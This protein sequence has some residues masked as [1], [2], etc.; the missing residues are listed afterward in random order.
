MRKVFALFGTIAINGINTVKKDLTGLDKS[1]KDISKEMNKTGRQLKKLGKDMSKTFTVPI[2][3]MGAAATKFGGDFEKA[4][5]TSLAIMGD[6]SD[7]MKKDMSQAARDV[8]KTSTVSAKEAANAF[9]YLASA[10]MTAAQSLR[11]LPKV[12][13]FAQA[14]QFDMAIAT[15]LLTDAQSALGLVVSDVVENEKNL[16]R[17]SDVLVKANI[18]ANASVQ[19]FSESLTNRAGSALKILGKSVEEGIAVL[20]SYANQGVKG[21]EAGTQLG[22]VLRDLQSSA[23]GNK[24][25]FERLGISV[26]DANGDMN[27][28]ADI[29]FDLENALNGMSDAE[30][31]A[32][33][34]L[35]G[36]QDRS[37]QSLFTLI[38]TSQQIRNYEKALKS[39]GGTT[40]EVA[41]K[42]MQNFNDQIKLIRNRL[43]DAAIGLST[44]L[45]PVLKNSFLPVI[46]NLILQL[47]SAVKWFSSLPRYVQDTS[48]KI[49]LITA[50][51]GPAFVAI[52]SMLKAVAGLRSSVI[53]LNTVLIGT[54]FGMIAVA[55][56]AL[57]VAIYNLKK[58]YDDLKIAH[59]S[60]VS[61]MTK[62]KSKQNELVKGY[63]DLL[64]LAIDN[65][66]I[67]S[68]E[69][70]RTKLLANET[71]RLTNI[72]RELGYEIEG[73]NDVKFEAL[74]IITQEI[75]GV[76]DS[77]GALIKYANSTSSA[78]K[79]TN[80]LTKE[81]RK[82]TEEELAEISAFEEKEQSRIDAIVKERMDKL[83]KAEEDKV[84]IRRKN[85]EEIISK[86]KEWADIKD[87]TNSKESE[88]WRKLHDEKSRMIEAEKEA[89]IN[90]VSQSFGILSQF[91][92]NAEIANDNRYKKERENIENSTKSEEEKKL[93][94]ERLESDY[95]KKRN[96]IRKRQAIIDKAQALF[97]I[98]LNTAVSIT[99]VLWDPIMVGV[100]GA[101]GALQAAAVI[102]KPIPAEKGA[103]LPG[104]KAGT[105]LQ[106]GENSKPELV[107]PLTTGV[108]VLAD[109]LMERFAMAAAW[110][111]NTIAAPVSVASPAMAASG[112]IINVAVN[113]NFIGNNAAMRDLAMQIHRSIEGEMTRRGAI[114]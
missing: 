106:A 92:Q 31:K 6:V 95:E 25:E 107:L 52:G 72:A 105:L 55:A 42:Q 16:V 41:R 49:L 7:A 102:A 67:L 76:R 58:N 21:A 20:A 62:E 82:L 111:D 98:G 34:S 108:K 8:A 99:K 59:T 89:R 79:S 48:V 28:M 70:K 3:A 100:I 64:K 24:R 1:L 85:T 114:A 57:G 65:K 27:N 109:A 78:A 44:S 60:T 22:I 32:T 30:K 14:G 104:S 26:Y 68:D 66:D 94:L 15:D 77:T 63:N 101:L 37:V 81:V 88:H 13:K 38:G 86:E 45:L 10:G 18:L 96:S 9:Y 4:M 71:E 56:A 87:Q 23:I 17:V 69:S 91:N 61:I 29:L 84:E 33:M 112:M 83:R 40:E 103:Y 36:F 43:V 93:A 5:S 2:V 50:A 53:L 39:A 75:Q 113:G 97:E 11:S 54:P 74:N 19:Q 46:E 80:E 35:L 47:S 51:I 110:L 73:N 12:A 90:A